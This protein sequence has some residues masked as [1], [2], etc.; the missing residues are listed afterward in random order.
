[1]D[2]ARRHGTVLGA[3]LASLTTDIPWWRWLPLPWRHWSVVLRADAGDQVPEH[4]PPRG[5]AVVATGSRPTWI[6]F[7]CPCRKRHRVMVNVDPSR[8]PRWSILSERPLTVSPSIH[9]MDARYRC[10]YWI[11]R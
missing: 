4:L 3:K 1:E 8:S 7:D 11:R 9:F 6:A 2:R 10:H 5:A